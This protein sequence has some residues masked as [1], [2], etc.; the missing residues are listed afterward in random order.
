MNNL[1]HQD[2]RQIIDK[3]WCKLKKKTH[4]R[5]QTLAYLEDTTYRKPLFYLKVFTKQYFFKLY[6]L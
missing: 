2:Y 6:N 3:T 5:I 4:N 1:D